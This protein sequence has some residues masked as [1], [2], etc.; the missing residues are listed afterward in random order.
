[1]RAVENR[2]IK[3][4]DAEDAEEKRKDAEENRI[5]EMK[6]LVS[7]DGPRPKPASILQFVMYR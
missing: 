1:M 3:S 7:R 5:W 6:I 2:K 4:V